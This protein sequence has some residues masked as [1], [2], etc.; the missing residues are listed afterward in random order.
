MKSL[1]NNLDKQEL[2]QRLGLIKP[3]SARRWGKMTAGQMVCH[4][5]DSF[6]A[7]I[8]ERP[9]TSVNNILGPNLIKWVALT[10]R[11]AG[12]MASRPDRKT[13]RRLA[14]RSQLIS[15]PMSANWKSWSIA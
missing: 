15:P 1:S 14:A 3:E 7:V 10:C 11:S 6:K 2:L 9:V 5:N 12:R 4:L 8:G 13:I